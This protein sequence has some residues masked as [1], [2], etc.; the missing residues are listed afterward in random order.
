[1]YKYILSKR[2]QITLIV[3]LKNTNIRIGVNRCKYLTHT[4]LT[5]FTMFPNIYSD[6]LHSIIYSHYFLIIYSHYNPL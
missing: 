5:I 2:L 3:D 1:M 4:N 6:F